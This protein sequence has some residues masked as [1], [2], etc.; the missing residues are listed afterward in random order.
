MSQR[1]E[2]V[3]YWVTS[4]SRPG[5]RV[6]GG[7]VRLAWAASRASSDCTAGRFPHRAGMLRRIFIVGFFLAGLVSRGAADDDM[8]IS[9][10]AVRDEITAAIEAQLAAFR[11]NDVAKA[12]DFAAAGLRTQTTVTSFARM[13][14]QNYPEIWQSTRAEFGLVRDDG[15]KARLIVHVFA[16]TG[17]ASYDYVLFKEKAGWRIGGVLRR[18]ARPADMI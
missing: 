10:P 3:T 9:K 15:T 8:H 12:F 18:E 16:K 13:V 11:A 6:A 5:E 7:V 4:C 2:S 1:L 14:R 17:E